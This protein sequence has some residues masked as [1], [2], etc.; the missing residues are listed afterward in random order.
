MAECALGCHCNE[1]L[2]PSH[3]AVLGRVCEAEQTQPGGI[4]KLW[5]LLDFHE[6]A[7]RSIERALTVT[8]WSG[9]SLACPSI[10][11][12]SCFQEILTR[13]LLL[14]VG[15][16]VISCFGFIF[17]WFYFY[18]YLEDAYG[19]ATSLI[20]PELFKSS[21]HPTAL[22]LLSAREVERITEYTHLGRD[23]PGSSSPTPGPAQGIP[24]SHPV[25]ESIVQMLPE[26]W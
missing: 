2:E 4:L 12:G 16:G 10:P 6:N 23:S 17:L 11:L 8:V 5:M 21:R 7:R 22:P 13:T 1:P 15:V 20:E 14:H 24:K 25:S 3:L 9:L 26:L 18:L 19:A